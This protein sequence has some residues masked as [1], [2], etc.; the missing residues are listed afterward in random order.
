MI[1]TKFYLYK[2]VS[3]GN[4][5]NSFQPDQYELSFKKA[6]NKKNF[7]LLIDLYYN[8]MQILG[9]KLFL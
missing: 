5:D 2:Q 4:E 6:S 8:S 3:F 1:D 9:T 7:Q